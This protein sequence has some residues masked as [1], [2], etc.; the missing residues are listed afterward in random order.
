MRSARKARCL[1]LI[2]DTQIKQRQLGILI[3]Q[4]T[5]IVNNYNTLIERNKRISEST[6]ALIS[7]KNKV[8]SQI[9]NYKEQLN[10]CDE[11]LTILYAALT[12]LG[13]SNSIEGD[14]YY[15]RDI[16]IPVLTTS[17][18]YYDTDDSKDTYG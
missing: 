12:E 18:W 1:K 15:T 7:S 9:S 14:T 10:I 17:F 8:Q 16:E 4:Y 13:A 11:R 6:E 5:Q 2:Q 3:E